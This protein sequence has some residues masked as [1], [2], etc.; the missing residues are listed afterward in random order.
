MP[1]LQTL[2]D[3]HRQLQQLLPQL[4]RPLLK[5]LAA[6]TCGMVWSGSCTLSRAAATLPTPV[7]V[8]STVRRFQRLLAHP[9]VAV[10][11]CQQ[12]LA[13]QVLADHQGRLDVL[14]DATTTGTTA[15][16]PGTQS[17]VL[18]L[19]HQGQAIPLGWQCWQADA[20]GQDWTRAQES[21]FAHLEAVRP[22]ATQVVVM[23]DRGLSGAPLLR[24]AQTQGWHYL[25]RV[26]RT[27]RVQLADG[28]VVPIGELAPRPGTQTLLEGV[29]F[30]ASRHKPGRQRVSDWEQ[31]L[32]TNVVAVWRAG[33]PEPWLLVTDLPAERRRC[34]EY[35]RRTWEEAL[36]RTLKRM[37]W[38]WQH[39]RVQAPD[40]VA[41]LLLVMALAT[42]W[43]LALGQRVVRRGWR[44][45]L[46]PRSRR[47]YSRF[48]L[49]RRWVLRCH[50][51]EHHVPCYLHFYPIVHAPLKLS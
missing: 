13:A 48:Q 39:S 23:A 19:G 36:F 38:G 42:L 44:H 35:R 32:T 16:Q 45:A 22:A 9:D 11:A 31:A 8:P 30:Y 26:T 41:R 37:G 21:L 18:A 50:A 34:A 1:R 15:Q 43:M 7:Q 5:S 17:L 14:L 49:G 2:H 3:C 28:Q 51:L 10:T 4:S 29:K 27:T 6:F 46:E 33:D 40:R 24:R 12:A 25:V 20:R 47:C